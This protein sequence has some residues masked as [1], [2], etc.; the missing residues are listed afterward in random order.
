M[1]VISIIGRVGKDPES[2]TTST[3]TEYATFSVAVKRRGAQ[4]KTDWFAVKAWGK[5]AG[6][7]MQYVAKGRQV[8]ITG[9]V[10]IDEWEGQDGTR[11]TTVTVNANDVQ[12]LD[13]RDDQGGGQRDQERF[14]QP[15]QRPAAPPKPKQAE[16][17]WRTD[18]DIPPF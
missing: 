15:A 10:Q 14:A 4:D 18:D 7:C 5:T 11:R 16:P 1:N 2:R 9:S 8:A 13:K 12:L 6:V 3:G 17:S